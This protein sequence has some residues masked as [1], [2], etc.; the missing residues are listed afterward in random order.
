MT[1]RKIP[2]QLGLDFIIQN[3]PKPPNS[4][5]FTVL[6]HQYIDSFKNMLQ[7][8]N[9]KYLTIKIKMYFKT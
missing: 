2:H 8:I 6:D 4:Q 9:H 5:V 3:L 7:E 1:N